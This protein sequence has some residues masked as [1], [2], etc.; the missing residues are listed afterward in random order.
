MCLRA[1]RTILLIL[2][3]LTAPAYAI[4][5]G[6]PVTG[7]NAI[8][9]AI[10]SSVVSVMGWCSGVL[11]G[12]GRIYTAGHCVADGDALLVF[13]N[14]PISPSSIQ[15][16]TTGDFAEVDFPPEQTPSGYEAATILPNSDVQPGAEIIV[17]GYGQ[18]SA[19]APLDGVLRY[20]S[21]TYTGVDGSSLK[22]H[23]GAQGVC[24]GD[25]GGPAYIFQ[26]G[27]L[28][29]LGINQRGDSSCEGDSWAFLADGISP[30]NLESLK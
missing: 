14:I 17:A 8:E 13:G 2:L 19:D 6:K 25:S 27:T 23:D 4:V 9:V 29:L 26:N 28:Y 30:S 24:H 21:I 16:G 10:Q 18:T 22:F 5:G 3:T 15:I 11:V 1:T 12:P 7:A 20:A